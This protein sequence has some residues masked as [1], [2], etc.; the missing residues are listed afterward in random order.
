MVGQPAE[1]PE[2]LGDQDLKGPKDGTVPQWTE[3]GAGEEEGGKGHNKE[4]KD[5]HRDHSGRTEKLP[6]GQ[7]LFMRTFR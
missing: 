7:R 1:S 3:T 5:A 4:M 6:L 2:I